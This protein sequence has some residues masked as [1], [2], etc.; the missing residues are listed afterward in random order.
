MPRLYGQ[1]HL[2]DTDTPGLLLWAATAVAF[3][4][5]LH[6]PDA[7]RWRVAVGV[8]LGLAF[9]EKMGA[10]MVLL[11]LLLWLM[12][13]GCR[14]P[15]FQPG[16]RAA[17][18]RRH[19]DGGFDARSAG[20]GVPADPDPAAAVSAA[21]RLTD[22]F[23]DRPVSDWP[24]AILAIPLSSGRSAGCWAGFSPAAR[25]GGSSG[26][27]SR[28]G[29][30]SW[31]LRRSSAGWATRPGGG[32]HCRDWPIITRSPSGRQ[33][34]LP[35]ISIIYFGQVYEFSLP[36]HNGWV[37]MAITVPLAILGAARSGMLG[38]LRIS[39]DRLPLYFLIH[40]LTLPDHPDVSDAGARRR[41]A[42]SSHV[43]LPGGLRGLGH[44]LAG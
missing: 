10:V 6:E 12:W 19:A 44:R 37:L 26:R 2:I 14:E 33:G 39:R 9:I 7:R 15:I 35:D 29:R 41:A 3:W 18:D 17:L 28:P 5:G 1:A 25:S 24:G 31:R 23:L 22:L 13:A 16:A 21:A 30:R 11:P 43:L 40:F 38:A 34:A 36:W 8:L 4:K 32:K 42:V 20:P 27:H